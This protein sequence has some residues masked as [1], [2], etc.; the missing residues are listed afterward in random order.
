MNTLNFASGQEVFV[1]GHLHPG[2]ETYLAEVLSK[3]NASGEFVRKT[4]DLGRQV[5]FDAC[6]DTDY[7]DEVVFAQRK[8]RPGLSRLV[9]KSPKPTSLVT[10][11]VAPHQ[12]QVGKYALLTA[13]FGRL[14]PQ[15]PTDLVFT[16]RAK[17]RPDTDMRRIESREFWSAHALAYNPD[18]LI[19]GTETSSV[20]PEFVEDDGSL[21][22][23]RREYQ[24]SYGGGGYN[25]TD[26]EICD[27]Y[28]G[29][30][31]AK[32]CDACGAAAHSRCLLNDELCPEC[33][34]QIYDRIDGYG[35]RSHPNL[36]FIDKKR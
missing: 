29:R 6:I 3:I 21:V 32:Y 19:P 15:E 20:P 30:G 31:E 18:E 10:V 36:K 27:M 2:V 13:F 25:G 16:D 24:S 4:V 34:N 33:F 23:V 26:C 12:E 11:I 17:A 1:V 5:G 28:L 22:I 8:G 9:K 14:A 7:D 35:L